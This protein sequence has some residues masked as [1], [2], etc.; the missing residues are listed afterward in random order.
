MLDMVFA[1]PQ[2]ATEE[3]PS[4]NH[5]YLCTQ[6]IKQLLQ[7]PEILPLAEL[8]LNI[9][10][11]LTPDISIY[12]ADKIN[13]DFFNDVSKYDELPIVA[14]EIIS[15]SQN[16]QTVLQKA[17]QLTAAGVRSVLTLEPYSRTVFVTQENQE[18]RLVHNAIVEVEGIA[19]DFKHIFEQP[20]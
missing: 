13:P 1:E 3:M 7:L 19:I 11:G 9:D 16:I 8:T 2:E 18:N 6:I 17:K 5:S 12:P 10:K 20:G 15:A 14:I 4:L